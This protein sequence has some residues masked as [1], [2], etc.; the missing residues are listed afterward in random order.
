MRK[1]RVRKMNNF[2]YTHTYIHIY[3]TYMYIYNFLTAYHI[4]VIIIHLFEAF[5]IAKF[6]SI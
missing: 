4:T 2:H 1:P 6:M 5:I 3:N